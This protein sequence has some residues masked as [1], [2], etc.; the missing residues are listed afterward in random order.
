MLLS[1]SMKRKS[2]LDVFKNFWP[3]RMRTFSKNLAGW[4]SEVCSICLL[5]VWYVAAALSYPTFTI[6]Y[7]FGIL[8]SYGA[9]PGS[10]VFSCLPFSLTN[11]Q[12]KPFTF[13][14]DF[15]KWTQTGLKSQTA[16]RCCSIYIACDLHADFA[17]ACENVIS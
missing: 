1:I 15:P 12:L 17:V 9:L 10:L 16:L 3:T 14:F 11:C 4:N 7:Y 8:Y 13:I 2:Q 5:A 6:K